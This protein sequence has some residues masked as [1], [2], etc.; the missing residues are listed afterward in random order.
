[1]KAS[2]K[3]WLGGKV[4]HGMMK[5]LGAI[6]QRLTT[7]SPQNALPREMLE[8]GL[9][10]E[11]SSTYRIVKTE[12]EHTRSMTEAEMHRTRLHGI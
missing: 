12:F 8:N 11:A 10:Y 7:I 5:N 1:M 3:V 6:H 2:L 9:P 4:L